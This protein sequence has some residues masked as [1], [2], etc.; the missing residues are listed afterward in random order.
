MKAKLPRNVR[1]GETSQ[2][3]EYAANGRLIKGLERA[4]PPS[5]Y[6]AMEDQ[7]TGGHSSVWGSYFDKDEL[8]WGACCWQTARNAYCVGEAGK[9]AVKESK[10]WAKQKQNTG[11][12]PSE[13]HANAADKARE[14]RPGSDMGAD[15]NHS[16]NRA[17]DFG[18]G[19]S[20]VYGLKKKLDPEKLRRE[21]A[22]QEAKLRRDRG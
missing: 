14:Q 22:L 2:Y 6:A 5:K 8:K 13:N 21:I 7:H 10:A 16:W 12:A 3:A 18:A 15:G 1:F 4:A 19:N 17:D 11:S 9:A 20:T